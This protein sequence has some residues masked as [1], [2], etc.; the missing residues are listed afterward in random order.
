MFTIS[1]LFAIRGC[2]APH[3]PLLNLNQ[4]QPNCSMGFL[5]TQKNICSSSSFRVCP[6]PSGCRSLTVHKKK[7]SVNRVGVKTG[8][9]VHTAAQTSPDQNLLRV[10]T[11]VQPPRQT[12]SVHQTQDLS[13]RRPDSPPGT[14][15]DTE[16]WY[17]AFGK[18]THR[19]V[20]IISSLQLDCVC[21]SY[22]R[23]SPCILAPF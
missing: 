21:E 15:Q 8:A 9:T 2:H 4:S 19:Q 23:A 22:C 18:C 1:T 10:Q 7:T 13:G 20:C 14:P 6:G 11:P 3:P 16:A 5:F 17:F 12:S